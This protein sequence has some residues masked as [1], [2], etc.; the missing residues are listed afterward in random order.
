[1]RGGGGGGGGGGGVKPP[2]LL[3]TLKLKK[4]QMNSKATQVCLFLSLPPLSLSLFLSLSLPLFSFFNCVSYPLH[5]IILM[6]CIVIQA[7]IIVD[8]PKLK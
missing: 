8:S 1:M 4:N 3:C 6:R 2:S 7:S 5:V